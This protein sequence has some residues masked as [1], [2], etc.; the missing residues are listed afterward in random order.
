MWDTRFTEAVDAS[1]SRMSAI[2][3]IIPTAAIQWKQTT[4]G[5]PSDG[6]AATFAYV[7][8]QAKKYRGYHMLPAVARMLQHHD[9]GPYL[10]DD[11]K[12]LA[13]PLRDDPAQAVDV[14]AV[15]LDA[16]ILRAVDPVPVRYDTPAA[17]FDRVGAMLDDSHAQLD[18]AFGQLPASQRD[19][20]AR[21][22]RS[23]LDVMTGKSDLSARDDAPR[24]IRAMRQT[25]L[26]DY[27]ALLNA[28]QAMMP[29]VD[30]TRYRLPIRKY[31]APP[32]AELRGAITGGIIAARKHRGRWIVYGGSGDNTYDMT[33]IAVVIDPFGNDVYTFGPTRAGDVKAVVDFH[34]NDQYLGRGAGPAGAV[35]GVQLVVDHAG[36][37]VYRGES[38]SHGAAVLGVG[39]LVD[40][41]GNDRYVGTTFTQGAAMYGFGAAIDLGAG[42]DSYTADAFSQGLGGPR[43]LGMLLNE[44][45]EEYY[46]TSGEIDSV[47]G[48]PATTF[49]MSQGVG[50]GHRP[51]D[52]G[53]VGWLIDYDGNDRYEAGEFSQG[54]GYFT[55]LGVLQDHRGRD[56]YFGGRY[57]QGFAAHQAAGLFVDYDGD[58]QYYSSSAAGQGF[59]WD[60]S[61]ALC[62]D[63]AGNDSYRADNLSQGS[64]AQQAVGI[65]IDVGGNDAYSGGGASVQGRGGQNEYHFNTA[66]AYSWSLLIDLGGVDSYS[67]GLRNNSHQV[68]DVPSDDPGRAFQHGMAID[69]EMDWEE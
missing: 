24:I 27:A 43:G 56:L 2:A 45:G 41:A 26:V 10:A 4:V 35:M 46:R 62:L 48:T 40:Y 60:E 30:T 58:D 23:L 21:D 18:L 9:H 59:A 37:D 42:S 29:L 3:Q 14:A 12:G 61:V 64:A 47:Y 52:N 38:I 11:F 25:M 50:F 55:G 15:V 19:A 16:G 28:G 7:A 33:R 53:G 57:A 44:H 54:G 66:R 8:Q 13:S 63:M 22:F 31:H 17:L 67:S 5:A 34:G 65:L 49:A 32:P 1:N 6:V 51:F 69:V 68:T 39:M 36:D 20:M